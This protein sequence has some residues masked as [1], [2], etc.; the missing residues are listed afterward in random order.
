MLGETDAQMFTTCAALFGDDRSILQ[1]MTNI[2]KTNLSTYTLGFD[3]SGRGAENRGPPT[4][5]DMIDLMLH[6]QEE[7]TGQ[8]AGGGGGGENHPERSPRSRR[9]WVEVLPKN[10]SFLCVYPRC[11][12][13][14]K[15]RLASQTPKT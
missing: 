9:R 7:G 6:E 4:I 3:D 1:R 12:H 15:W 5:D 8:A 2:D 11:G 14:L 13:Y 10:C